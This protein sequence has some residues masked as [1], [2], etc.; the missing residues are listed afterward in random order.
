MKM[1]FYFKKALAIVPEYNEAKFELA[2][3]LKEVGE[4]DRSI[5]CFRDVTR[6]MP[7]SPDA[8]F[9][10]A[11]VLTDG[12]YHEAIRAYQKTLSLRSDFLRHLLTSGHYFMTRS[13][14]TTH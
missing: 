14:L 3:A 5:E 1:L 12:D 13:W 4:I 10:L 6:S 7:K 11:I 9:N 2:C 8:F